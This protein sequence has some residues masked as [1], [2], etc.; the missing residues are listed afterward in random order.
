LLARAFFLPNPAP[1]KADD[2]V[3]ELHVFCQKVVT[4]SPN[5]QEKKGGKNWEALQAP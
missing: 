4:P 1:E 5:R 2:W 3:M